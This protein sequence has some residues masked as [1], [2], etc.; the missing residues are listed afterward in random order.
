MTKFDR[1]EL[2]RI[3]EDATYNDGDDFFESSGCSSLKPGDVVIVEDPC[4]DMD[5]DVFVGSKD[6]PNWS[7]NY[8]FEGSLESVLPVINVGD[9][10]RVYTTWKDVAIEGVVNRFTE[11]EDNAGAH[12]Y[13]WIGKGSDIAADLSRP[14]DYQITILERAVRWP[15]SAGFIRI[16]GGDFAGERALAFNTGDG[17]ISIR[18]ASGEFLTKDGTREYDPDFDYQYVGA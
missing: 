5:G 1:G 6:H 12:K 2:V 14:Q 8:I 3:K 13:M 10:I 18:R 17:S 11:D 16:T 7:G 15:V 4:P 9:R